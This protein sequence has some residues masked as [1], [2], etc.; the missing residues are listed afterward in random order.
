MTHFAAVYQQAEAAGDRYVVARAAVHAGMALR[1]MGHLDEAHAALRQAA[2]LAREAGDARLEVQALW[3][4]KLVAD[5]SGEVGGDLTGPP[6]LLHLLALEELLPTI[7]DAIGMQGPAR[8]S[9]VGG[10]GS[11]QDQLGRLAASHGANDLARHYFA[12]ALQ[13]RP[14][15]RTHEPAGGE[16]GRAAGRRDSRRSG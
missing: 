6:M 14:G 3:N 5:N 11:T 13:P 15:L 10:M 9:Y 16:S 7:A 1:E 2:A 8:E 12:E 4:L